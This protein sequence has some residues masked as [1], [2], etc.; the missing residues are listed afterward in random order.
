MGIPSY[1]RKLTHS[2]KLVQH[3]RPTG[4]VDWLLF[5]FNCLIYHVLRRP[6]CPQ[7][8]PDAPK[9][10]EE[11][12]LNEIARYTLKVIKKVEPTK[13]VYIAVDGVA[14]MAKIR[15]QRMRRFKVGGTSPP[16][17]PL[18]SVDPGIARAGSMGAGGAG[19]NG[20][21]TCSPCWDKNAITPGTEFMQALANRLHTFA[22]SHS[23]TTGL[24]IQVSDSNTPGEGEQKL[25]QLLRGGSTPGSD[26]LVIYGLDADLIVLSLWNRATLFPNRP[27]YLFR[28]H[29]EHGEIERDAVGEEFFIWFD[30]NALDQAIRK[31]LSS[32][33]HAALKDYC[34]AMMLLGN[35]FLPTS[36]SFRLKE[37]GH[38]RLVQLLKL[39]G[40]PLLREGNTLNAAAMLPILEQLAAEE[41][42]RFARAVFKKLSAKGDDN[43]PE[44]EPLRQRADEIFT[45]PHDIRRLRSNWRS[46]YNTTAFGSCRAT[47]LKAAR[48]YIQG[49]SWVVDYYTGKDI[50]MEWVYN[51]HFAPQWSDILRAFR[52]HGW[53]EPPVANE[54]QL[55][56]VEQLGMVLPLSSWSLIP[57]SASIKRLPELAPEWFPTGFH[58]NSVG[59]RY[60]WEC[61]PDIPIPTPAQV[62]Q[63][64]KHLH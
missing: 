64:L 21:A 3:S 34:A 13:G 17:T 15:Q 18:C 42:S 16:H 48:T 45:Q 4:A 56:P 37:E 8:I 25:M 12:F 30:I 2:Y 62:L 38:Q 9:V 44:D 5:D 23:Q 55:Q 40:Q 57:A 39:S 46:I 49:L 32:E 6:D 29:V 54:H 58:M 31:E 50:S 47:P 11:K 24:K 52:E 43:E 51:W 33:S 41:E 14:P 7:Y 60:A 10:W 59:K 1:F 20:V 22:S 28:E 61:E 19:A 27:M 35:D 63:K 53:I 36:M 26:A